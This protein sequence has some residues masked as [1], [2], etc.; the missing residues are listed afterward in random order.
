MRIYIFLFSI[1]LMFCGLSIEESF[2][3]QENQVDAKDLIQLLNYSKTLIQDGEMKFLYYEHFPEIRNSNQFLIKDYERQLREN[4]P[5]SDN[6]EGLRKDILR[7]IEEEK[8][9][10]KFRDSNKKF[11]FVEFN[12]VFQKASPYAF[13]MEA[14]SRFENYP[15]FE[16]LRFFNGGGQ[17]F[18]TSNGTVTLKEILPAQVKNNAPIGT[19]IIRDIPTLPEV[20]TAIKILPTYLINVTESK[21]HLLEENIDEPIYLI[22]YLYGEKIKIKLY[23]KIESGLP[24]VTREELYYKS[25]S[26]HADAEGYWLRLVSIYSDFERVDSLNITVPKVRE[27]HEFRGRDGF[28][29]RRTIMVIKEMDFNLGLPIDFFDWDKSELNDDGGGQKWIRDEI[30][31]KEI[32]NETTK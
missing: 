13:R 3:E 15:S 19:F 12:L 18:F 14:I 6:P 31:K 10:G 4:P 29:R 2:S 9:F 24:E 30:P 21:V 25:D 5:K 8:K 26:P 7:H 17:S 27:M 23:V 11:T 20:I 22:T 16:S 1:V 28:K 32:D